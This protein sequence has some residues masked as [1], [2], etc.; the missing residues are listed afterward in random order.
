MGDF[1]RDLRH[2]ARQLRR[3]S[4]IAVVILLTLG[5]GIGA[6]TAI[7]S[8]VD[9]VLLRPL[10][11]ED[12]DELAILWGDE[13][14]LKTGSNWTSYPD[15]IDFEAQ[16]ESFERLAAWSGHSVTL[17]SYGGD[18]VR[19]SVGRVTWDLFAML[20]V[21]PVMGR[22]FLAEEDRVG[23]PDV[24]VLSHA[25]WTDRL[26]ADPEV[27]G[28]SLTLD[29]RPFEVIGVMARGFEWDGAE[30][31]APLSAEY[32]EDPRG[33][34]RIL[35]LARL[36]DGVSLDAADAEVAAIAA[37]LEAE[38]PKTNTKR[39]AYLEPLHE[40]A[41]GQVRSTLWAVFGMVGLVLLIACANV[42]NILLTRATERGQELAVRSALGAGR[43]HLVRQLGTESL[44]LACLGGAAG[45]AVAAVGL[46]LLKALSPSGIP[47]LE[48]VTLNGRVLLFA[49]VITM[50]TGIVFG[51]LPSL[52]AAR[53]NLQARLKEGGR[54]ADRRR[55]APLAQAVVVGEVALALVAV[56][57]AG[58]LLN[59]FVK[60]QNVDAGFQAENVLVVPVALPQGKYWERGDPN[61]RRT[62][63]F[64]EEAER[65]IAELP[66]VSSVA[67]AYMHPLSGGW[68][69]SFIIKGVLEPPEGDRPEARMRP[70]T[71]GYFRTVG[72]PLLKG[73]D[74]S[75]TDGPNAPGVVVVNESFE[76]TFFP[77]GDALGHTIA[78]GRWWEELPDEFE[79][80]GVVADV[81]MDGLA[82]SVPT[83]L[84]F[85]HPQFPFG[86]MNIVVASEVDVRTLL[87]SVQEA[88]WSID[89]DLPIEG[90]ETLGEIR[91][92]S[93]ASERFRTV[94]VGLFAAI[95][96][97]LSA[98]GIY[99]VLSYSVA[100][101]TREVGLRMSLGAQAADVVQL[102]VRQGM[103]LTLAG[104]VVGCVLALLATGALSSLLFEVSP[105]D[106]AT[107]AVV[108]AL[109]A[110]V[111]LLACLVPALRATRVDPIV[112]LR[113][114]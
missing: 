102:V 36:R 83:A 96:L 9:N 103:T 90:V 44:M 105:T 70:V 93:V 2:T 33:A 106:P 92:G 13:G 55:R 74:I 62:V 21:R 29:G 35:P 23:G 7:F 87:T 16:A 32:G 67:A 77:G 72:I 53:V 100:Q 112:A 113:A 57:S 64:Y 51:L 108:V 84:Y 101:R 71:P 38:Y 48:S 86:D 10:P 25:F 34:H 42:A 114:E 19:V 99:G 43:G 76:R 24:L 94:L 75:V 37:R 85:S 45:I 68:E 104:L 98:I 82:E 80:V 15:F 50:L 73:R 69:S 26:G 4:G 79:I 91:S 40:T 49:L 46:H 109:L 1:I 58:L 88:I 56:V 39:S 3:R 63:A 6:T 110:L 20:G 95:A 60:L 111:A 14:G 27:V 65:R 28:R 59:S 97:L 17:T 81:K 11:Y 107:F 89:S 30:V 8:V 47:R 18:P 41:V 5:L 22:G 31:F 61:G 54:H 66:G 52:Q 78:R 12:A